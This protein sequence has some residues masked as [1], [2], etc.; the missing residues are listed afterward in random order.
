MLFQPLV[1]TSAAAQGVPP[2]EPGSLVSYHET[3]VE[4]QPTNVVALS[5]AGSRAMNMRAAMESAL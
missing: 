2:R 5:N 1:S 3:L 4:M